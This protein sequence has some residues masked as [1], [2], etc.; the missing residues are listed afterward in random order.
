MIEPQLLIWLREHAHLTLDDL[1]RVAAV[2]PGT[3]AAWEAGTS[4]PTI[5][6]V[7]LI[8]RKVRRPLATFF[9]SEPPKGF[10]PPHDYR[11][12]FGGEVTV[13]AN[14]VNA[15]DEAQERR[16][17][18]LA[19][20]EDLDENPSPFQA[21]GSSGEP[22]ERLAD[23]L[24]AALGVSVEEQTRWR[25]PEEAFDAWRSAVERF[26]VLVFQAA[27]L[28]TSV[29]GFALFR[30]PLPCIVLNRSDAVV[31]RSF[32]LAH[33]L[34][35]LAMHGDGICDPFRLP[36]DPSPAGNTEAFCN[37]VAGA[38][39]VPA[40][41]I[42]AF[43]PTGSPPS[44]REIEALGHRFQTSCEVIVRRLS[45]LGVVDEAFYK[46]KRAEY[47]SARTGRPKR[48]SGRIPVPVDVISKVGRPF[49][50]LVLTGYRVGAVTST[51]AAAH[52]GARLK[53]FTAIEAALTR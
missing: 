28:P 43:L 34:A 31:A 12:V 13:D 9:L 8:A 2:T 6:Q 29:R 26:G 49:A 30:D 25:K 24:R 22:A 52:L 46:R 38:L 23:R 11:L 5:R 16:D 47:E 35:H 20:I 1:A 41:A 50:R 19:L 53:H 15:I 17:A 32:T 7:R 48:K 39:L 10:S 42:R 18:A 14:L 21:P 33:E 4:K 45:I 36:V 44:D 40:S 27:R 37:H 3:V 51:D